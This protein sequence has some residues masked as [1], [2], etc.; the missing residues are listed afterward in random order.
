MPGRQQIPS[1]QL[2]RGTTAE[3]DGSYNLTTVGSIFYNTDTSNVEICH[4]GL[5]N[6]TYWSDLVPPVP[7]TRQ[8]LFKRVTTPQAKQN[9]TGGSGGANPNAGFPDFYGGYLGPEFTIEGVKGTSN[10]VMITW[11]IN[12]E[13]DNAPWDKGLVVWKEKINESGIKPPG[14]EEFLRADPQSGR[15]AQV[16]MID[17]FM[18]GNDDTYTTQDQVNGFYIDTDLDDDF[19]YRYTPVLVN[20]NPTTAGFYMGRTRN[21]LNIGRDELTISQFFIQEF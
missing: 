2:P 20:S 16:R 15:P 4:E 1:F 10:G 3:R 17:G 13:W 5:N 19:T 6:N 21:N 12:G 9:V 14:S 8:F 7:P 11:D 18:N